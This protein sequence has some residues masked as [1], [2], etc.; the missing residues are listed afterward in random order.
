[1]AAAMKS[2]LSAWARQLRLRLGLD[3]MPTA[4]AQAVGSITPV[5]PRVLLIIYNPTVPSA[6]GRKLN[7]VLEWNDPDDLT[8]RYIEDVRECSFGYANYE[9][10]ERL[11]VDDMPQKVDGFS[12]RAD[13]FVQRWRGR[14]GFHQP[15]AVDYYRILDNFRLVER[16]NDDAIDEVWLQGFPFAGFYESMMVG[17]GAFWCNAPPLSG[18]DHCRRRFVIM[19]FSYERGVGEMLENLGHRAE[20]IIGHLFRHTSGDANLWQRFS[21]YDQTHPGRAEVGIMHFAPNSLRD[22]DWGNPT[23]VPSRC[24]DWRN[25]P[26]FQ[27]E[28]HQLNC[29]DWGNGDIRAHHLWWFRLLPHVAGSANAI[30]HN[31]WEYIIDPNKVG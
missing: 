31:W 20:S 14:S 1:L 5:R 15:D 11:E 29:Q 25:F 4:Q 22:Y 9:V 12:Y 10:V 8:R 17:P 30:S 3:P 23:Y 19:G 28:A 26:N 27:G 6:G 7:D 2:T 16:I 18:A 21:R 13:D 24:H